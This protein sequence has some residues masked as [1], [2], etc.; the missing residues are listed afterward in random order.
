M[1]ASG[2]HQRLDFEILAV[3]CLHICV[4]KQECGQ[5]LARVRVS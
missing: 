3:F 2:I 1:C 5:T 4:I